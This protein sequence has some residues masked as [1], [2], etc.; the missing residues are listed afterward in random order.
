MV[1]E[2]LVLAG[3]G[4]GGEVGEGRHVSY[5]RPWSGACAEWVRRRGATARS[6]ASPSAPFPAHVRALVQ[7][8][9]QVLAQ[10][11]VRSRSAADLQKTCVQ[12]RA[13]P[14]PARVFVACAPARAPSGADRSSTAPCHP[15]S[16][17]HPFRA[18]RLQERW[19]HDQF[20]G[21]LG[22]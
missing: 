2:L 20:V 1:R 16:R 14:I 13:G 18:S 17:S 8:H 5:C 11:R 22:P 7:A 10:S 15:H 9:V 21:H 4:G 12:T 6:L 3:D 19:G